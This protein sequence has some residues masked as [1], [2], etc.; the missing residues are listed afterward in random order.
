[1]VSVSV[2]VIVGFRVIVRVKVSVRMQVKSKA[3]Q[4]C[5]V[6]VRLELLRLCTRFSH[7][8]ALSSQAALVD[9]SL[10]RVC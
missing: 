10:A 1:M 9:I 7:R 3:D 5:S 2:R 8:K 6:R 4:Q